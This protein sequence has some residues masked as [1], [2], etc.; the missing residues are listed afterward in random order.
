MCPIR[1]MRPIGPMRPIAPDP[2]NPSHPASP[3]Q[4]SRGV[5]PRSAALRRESSAPRNRFPARQRARTLRDRVPARQ[6]ARTLPAISIPGP[7]PL[8]KSHNAPMAPSPC[9]ALR[10]LHTLRTLQPQRPRRAHLH[11]SRHGESP[12]ETAR[13]SHHGPLMRESVSHHVCRESSPAPALCARRAHQSS[14]LK[15]L[16]RMAGSRASSSAPVWA[17][18]DFRRSSLAWRSSR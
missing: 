6:G 18:R 13:G 4:Q 7:P 16:S 9:P 1:P 12:V 14:P 11:P 8:R 10:T 2:S 5:P 17:W 3:P 15:A